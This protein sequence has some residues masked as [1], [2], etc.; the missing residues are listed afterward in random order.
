MW[1]LKLS[2]PLCVC[3]QCEEQS[4]CDRL[5]LQRLAGGNLLISTGKVECGSCDVTRHVERG[6][7]DAVL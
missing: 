5:R 2:F 6:V 3:V 7:D 1:Y 4:D